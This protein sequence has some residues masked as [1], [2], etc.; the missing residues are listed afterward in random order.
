MKNKKID[1][2]FERT[3]AD[4]PAPSDTNELGRE[5][6]YGGASQD[7]TSFQADEAE[8]AAEWESRY[9]SEE[10]RDKLGFDGLRSYSLR[11]RGG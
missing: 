4:S 8:E 3:V 2:E 9:G 10:S 1:V 6:H 11:S 5:R 7:D